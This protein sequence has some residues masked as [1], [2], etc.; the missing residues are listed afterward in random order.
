M[1]TF[2]PA[3]LSLIVVIILVLVLEN[4]FRVGKTAE[5]KA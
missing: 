3:S 2:H 4:L 1:D 5:V